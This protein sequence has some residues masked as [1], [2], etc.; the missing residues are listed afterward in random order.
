LSTDFEFKTHISKLRR[1]TVWK[2]TAKILWATLLLALIFNT[3]ARGLQKTG[4]FQW[5]GY[6]VYPLLLLV[7]FAFSTLYHL[8]RKKG[9]TDTLIDIDIRLD[10]KE[11]L[12]TV[13]EYHQLDKRSL[14]MDRLMKEAI[15]LLGTLRRKQIFPRHFTIVHLL[16]P[17]FAIMFI[18]VLTVDLSPRASE[19]ERATTERLR[20]IGIELEKYTKQARPEKAEA[21]KETEK[22]LVEQMQAIARALQEGSMKEKRLL[23]SLE[24]IMNRTESERKRLT[25]RLGEELGLGDI[26]SIPE[27]QDLRK[28]KPNPTELARLKKELKDL[29]GGEVPPSISQDIS[30]LALHHEMAQFLKGA[31]ENV[32][33]DFKEETTQGLSASMS[34]PP[35]GRTEDQPEVSEDR[36]AEDEESLFTAGRR[37]AEAEKQAPYDLARLKKPALKDKG[38][39]GRGDLYN[40]SVR[41]L[42]AIGRARLKEEEIIRTYQKEFESVLQ[43]EDIPLLYREYVKQYFLSIGMGKEPEG[44][45]DTQ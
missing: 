40:T 9:F 4:I 34:R 1:L 44:N 8:H 38:V 30:N 5:E 24:G 19:Q 43:K 39:S 28:D 11:R 6:A 41:S 17:V 25:R 7:S 32:G 35:P 29:F 20:Q 13:Y 31:M 27:L 45:G 23:K 37:K 36:P 10:L 15:N 2:F 22:E 12:T 14:F 26:S 3:V 33:S 42:P 18:L 21:K 16:I